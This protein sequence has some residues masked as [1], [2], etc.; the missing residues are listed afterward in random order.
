MLVQDLQKEQ[1]RLAL[2]NNVILGNCG[3]SF[4]QMPFCRSPSIRVA[5]LRAVG[6]HELYRNSPHQSL[7]RQPWKIQDT[8]FPEEVWPRRS[9]CR[10]LLPSRVGRLRP[11][12][13]R[14]AGWQIVPP[15]LDLFQFLILFLILKWSLS[16]DLILLLNGIKLKKMWCVIRA[17]SVMTVSAN[18]V[19]VNAFLYLHTQEVLACLQLKN[20]DSEVLNF[21][22]IILDSGLTFIWLHLKLCICYRT[23]K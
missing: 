5:G 8:K 7:W 11:Q 9:N 2:N 14:T 10:V 19:S 4:S 17:S 16:S 1:V 15:H 20:A 3:D 18:I 22:P 6:H 23:R 21:T 13:L 12:T